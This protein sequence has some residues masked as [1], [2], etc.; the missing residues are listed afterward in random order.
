MAEGLSEG[1]QSCLRG[2][3]CSME[4][5][6]GGNP[7]ATALWRGTGNLKAELLPPLAGAVPVSRPAGRQAFC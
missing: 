6:T 2:S 5:G 3:S 1:Q 4:S 7:A